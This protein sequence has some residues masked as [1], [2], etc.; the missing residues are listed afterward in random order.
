MD[1]LERKAQTARGELA[2]ELQELTRRLVKTGPAVLPTHFKLELEERKGDEVR[3]ARHIDQSI[4]IQME[5]FLYSSQMRSAQLVDS[6][7]RCFD[8]PNG[9]GAACMARSVLESHAAIYRITRE[10]SE[11]AARSDLKWKERGVKFHGLLNRFL[12][13]SS[14]QPLREIL[15]AA[16]TSKAQ[17]E[18]FNIGKSIENLATEGGQK[19]VRERYDFLS[20]LIHP[21]GLGLLAMRKRPEKGLLGHLPDSGEI[22]MQAQPELYAEY[23]YPPNPGSIHL[24][25]RLSQGVLDDLRSSLV[26]LAEC[27]RSPFSNEEALALGTKS[28]LMAL[29]RGQS[30]VVPA[31]HR[32][33]PGRRQ[34][35]TC[36]SGKRYKNCCGK[37]L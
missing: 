14:L 8:P 27:P 30:P 9:L 23:S 35:C 7:L 12:W 26:W 33:K 10:L 2:A 25:L 36:G 6:F 5:T 1:E 13:S 24:L 11:T 31:T 28:K 4:K 15:T 17:R 16:G 19:A 18:P 32:D 3:T 34:P 37:K 29:K 21:N 20:D 22:G